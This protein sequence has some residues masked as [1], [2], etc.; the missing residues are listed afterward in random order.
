MPDTMC[1]SGKGK[2]ILKEGIK[3]LL[4]EVSITY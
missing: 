3:G 4:N 1:P 2:K